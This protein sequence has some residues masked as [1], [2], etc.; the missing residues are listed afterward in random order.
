MNKSLE[1]AIK[2]LCLL[3]VNYF[4]WKWS[5]RPFWK[6]PFHARSYVFCQEG[7]MKKFVSKRFYGSNIVFIFCSVWT[8]EGSIRDVHSIFKY[9]L[10][11]DDVF[12]YCHW[13]LSRMYQNAVIVSYKCTEVLIFKIVLVIVTCLC[14]LYYEIFMTHILI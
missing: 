12:M 6:F 1:F 9:S 8:Q 10:T 4:A 5:W 7:K 2:M 3:T 13:T 11:T 14:N